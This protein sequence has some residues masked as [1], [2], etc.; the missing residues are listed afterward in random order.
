MRQRIPLGGVSR[1]YNSRKGRPRS[2]NGYIETN[3]DRTFIRH[4]RAPG[5]TN[6]IAVG[7]GPIRAMYRLKDWVYVVSR[8][9]LY[10]YNATGTVQE[11][12]VVGG[13]TELAKINA[14]GTDV[15]QVI[16]ISEGNG[17]LYDDT[18]GFQQ[19]TDPDF[20]ADLH[21]ASLNQI[22]WVN[23][24]DSNVF[25][26]S[27]VA[28]GTDWPATRF[29]S[30][31]QS[32]DQ[33]IGL[34][35]T[36]TNLWVFG[37]ETVEYWQTDTT[38]ATLPLRP[39]AGATIERGVGSK[40]SIAQFQ[41]QIFWLADDYTVWKIEGN[42][43][44]KISDLNLEYAIR[45]EGYGTNR[46]Y[47][48]PQFAEGFFIDHPV[49]KLYVLTF[50]QD[51]ATWVYDA[52]TDEWHER[53]SAGL[54]RWR[55]RESVLAFGKNFVG[56][57]RDGTVWE[58]SDSVF[59]EDGETLKYQL[60]TP[61]FS[62]S[63]A[64]V[65]ISEVELTMEVGVGD[66]DAVDA[67][68]VLKSEPITPLLQLEYSKDGGVTWRHVSEGDLSIGQIGDRDIKV[69][70][71]DINELRRGFNLVFRITIT[72]KVPVV[73]YDLYIDIERGM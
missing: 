47:I 20:D 14:N 9:K 23:K 38:N 26:G 27:L 12:G 55:G 22:F 60:T 45:G 4:R 72:D 49:H 70:A 7:L 3:K 62:N 73:L 69:I 25:I 59:D 6:P 36:K 37:A 56:D 43:A 21:V 11:L 10:R 57:Y 16:V 32:P 64:D 61:S 28:D 67:F 50:P 46:G 51:Q 65:Y 15:N 71:R 17:Y 52:S 54:T 68:G 19:I 2:L 34:A 1:D 58:F 44:R 30:A 48:G 63:E 31:E 42:S 13:S 18:S 33:V 24:P 29:A 8:D 5:L 35:A 53:E 66:I 40:R 41:D 39:V